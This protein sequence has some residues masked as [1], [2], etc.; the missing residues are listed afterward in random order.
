MTCVWS[1][2]PEAW[3]TAGGNT[4]GLVVLEEALRVSQ[5]AIAAERLIVQGEGSTHSEI[6]VRQLYQAQTDHGLNQEFA[7]EVEQSARRW[8]EQEARLEAF[9]LRQSYARKYEEAVNELSGVWHA[10]Q[11]QVHEQQET[12]AHQAAQAREW[13]NQAEGSLRDAQQRAFNWE[14]EATASEQRAVE[15]LRRVQEEQ[16]LAQAVGT[17]ARESREEVRRCE[18]ERAEHFEQRRMD[19]HALEEARVCQAEVAE[20][21]R[22]RMH[23]VTQDV[24]TT[25]SQLRSQ[26]EEQERIRIPGSAE[27][28]RLVIDLHAWELWHTEN[29]V[30]L[31]DEARQAVAEV[32]ALREANQQYVVQQTQRLRDMEAEVEAARTGRPRPFEGVNLNQ[33][34]LAQQATPGSQSAWGPLQPVGVATRVFPTPEPRPAQPS[35]FY[36]SAIPESAA[37]SSPVRPY[38]VPV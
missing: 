14:T 24:G 15:A 34:P 1:T 9:Q 6:L 23:V 37:P 13:A 35:S 33:A 21:N 8:A 29:T 11:R 17:Q 27:R 10:Q 19:Q 25:A 12:M 38:Q 5:S 30:P 3:Q 16:L 28:E 4:P 20:Q 2:H 36:P 31:Q 32:A 7:Q 26:L 22:T 18:A